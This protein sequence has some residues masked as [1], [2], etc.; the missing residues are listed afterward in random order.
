MIE[1]WFG[2]EYQSADTRLSVII[3]F[4]PV[5]RHAHPVA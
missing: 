3:L 2:I 1:G 4:D 5:R